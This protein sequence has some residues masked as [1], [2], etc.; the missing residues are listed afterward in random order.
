M[1]EQEVVRDTS[2]SSEPG[3]E[4]D[5][6]QNDEQ[7]W[8]HYKKYQYLLARVAL[9]AAIV[10]GVYW[11]MTSVR[12]VFSAVF[13]SFLIAYL[14][15]PVIDWMEERGVGRPLGIVV[16]LLVGLGFTVGFVLF[17]YPTIAEQVRTIGKKFPTLLST[18]ETQ[19]LPWIERTFEYEVPATVSEA[20]EKYSQSIADALP[21]ILERLSTWGQGILSST[22]AI[23]ASL[24]NLVLI[25]VFVFYFLRDFDRIRVGVIEY[26]P[27]HRRDFVLERARKMDSVVGDW[28]RGQMQVAVT[29]AVLYAIGLGLAFYLSGID[30][31]AGIA[32]GVL[33]GLLNFIP[34]FGVAIG[35]ILALLMVLIN[36][37]GFGPL[38]GV[39]LVFFIVQSLEGYLITPK[40][41]GD[42]VGLRPVTVIIVLLIGG[43]L[44][45]LL[46]M[47]LAIPIFGA[48]KVLFPDI[49]AHYKETSFFTG[50][51]PV[52]GETPGDSA[53]PPPGEVDGSVAVGQTAKAE[54]GDD[55]D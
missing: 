13:L 20:L 10:F 35:L 25:P 47:L 37:S 8:H 2:S 4:A 26:I 39:G 21:S 49:I 51:D 6:E 50:R 7:R 28:V 16:V 46:G 42:K 32:I 30:T 24:L 33:G 48:V 5:A 44:F 41:V 22:G 9:W 1:S 55:E 19:T 40:V 31:Q 43:E 27:P 53:E 38:L 34:Y 29:L 12:S 54:R 3:R 52:T 36:W 14:L 15:D 23:V 17:L 18:I 11:L 45:G